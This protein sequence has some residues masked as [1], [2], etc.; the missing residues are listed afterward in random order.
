MATFPPYVSRETLPKHKR[1]IPLAS[2]V[3]EPVQ[4]GNGI[5]VIGHGYRFG[6][7]GRRNQLGRSVCPVGGLRAAI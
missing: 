3:A 1:L 6:E 4:V 7:S 5:H 2:L